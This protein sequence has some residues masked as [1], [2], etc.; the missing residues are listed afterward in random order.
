M[1]LCTTG[2][3]FADASDEFFEDRLLV[4]P[5]CFQLVRPLL[6]LL[7]TSLQISNL[8][9]VLVMLVHIFVLSRTFCFEGILVCAGLLSDQL[10][11][12]N[13][14]VSRP[15]PSPTIHLGTRRERIH[16]F[17]LSP[18]VEMIDMDN[19]YTDGFRTTALRP[20]GI[21]VSGVVAKTVKFR[22]RRS[23]MWEERK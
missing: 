23:G 3:P 12:I 7:N 18:T 10:Q 14:A 17:S 21:S 19:M 20:V 6:F 11:R 13:L 8:R 15:T 22:R 4:F 16:S 2:K 5:R 9:S 1:E